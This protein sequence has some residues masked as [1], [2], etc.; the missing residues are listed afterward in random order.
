MMDMG[1]GRVVYQED[2]NFIGPGQGNVPNNNDANKLFSSLKAND[3]IRAVDNASSILENDWGLV[4]STDF[5]VVT[6][7]RRLE[8]KEF[9]YHPQLGYISLYRKLQNDEALAV[10]YEYTNN[11]RR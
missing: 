6:A 3:N 2:N 11:G 9:T 8:D 4:K 10:A 1:E 7:A 5:E